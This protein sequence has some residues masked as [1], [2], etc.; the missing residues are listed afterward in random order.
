VTLTFDLWPW[1]SIG[2]QTLLRTK[3]VPSLVKV[4]WRMLILECSQRCYT[5]TNLPSDLD[6]W[7]WKSIGF[8][9][10]LKTKCVPSLVKIYWRMLILK[11]SQGCYAVNIWPGD[12]DL[13]PWKSIV[14]QILLRTKYVPSLVKIHWRM[15]IL[16]CSQGCYGRTD[17]SITIS[18]HNFV[19]EGIKIQKRATSSYTVQEGIEPSGQWGPVLI[20]FEPA[21]TFPCELKN[22][23]STCNHYLFEIWLPKKFSALYLQR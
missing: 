9:N 18:L 7:P 12:I 5:V 23:M 10:L 11:C 13:W 3:Y 4:H 17:G 21:S 8:Q 15:L 16:E 1:K 20:H 19:G 6:L 2:F 14:F 22:V